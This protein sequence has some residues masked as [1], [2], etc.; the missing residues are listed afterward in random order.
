MTSYP[1]PRLVY[2]C[3]ALTSLSLLV[4][5]VIKGLIIWESKCHQNPLEVSDGYVKF[6]EA[7]AHR[8][9]I[10]QDFRL[11]REKLKWPTGGLFGFF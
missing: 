3:Y 9:A 1:Q 4:A 10:M 2:S 8:S 11:M 7:E 6:E 5:L